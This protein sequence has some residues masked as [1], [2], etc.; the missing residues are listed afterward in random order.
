MGNAYASSKQ[1]SLLQPQKMEY[2]LVINKAG[3][4]LFEYKFRKSELTQESVLISGAIIAITSLMEEAFGINSNMKMIKFD[5]KDIMVE[6]K[7]DI[8]FLLVTERTSFFLS[9]CL[10]MFSESFIGQ[11]K[12]EIEN[13]IGDTSTFH[14]SADLLI[15]SFGLPVN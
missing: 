15:K 14:G 9:K 4:P 3:L 5:D 13:Y 1:L 8:A 6:I 12:N 7:K 11:F 2:L 10:K